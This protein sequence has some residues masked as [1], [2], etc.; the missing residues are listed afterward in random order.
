[1]RKVSCKRIPTNRLVGAPI[2]RVSFVWKPT[3]R[4]GGVLCVD[5]YQEICL[6]PNDEDVLRMDTYQW[7]ECACEEG[8]L[9]MDAN[10][11]VD[12]CYR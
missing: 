8:F 3:A 4:L 2:K 10:Q 12:G 5:T 6:Y 11:E 9:F 7:V 1:M